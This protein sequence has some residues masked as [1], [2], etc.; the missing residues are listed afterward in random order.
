[1]SGPLGS[2][3]WMYAS[4]AEAEGQSLRFNDDDSAYLSW[5]PASAGNRKTWTWS[6]WVKRGNIGVRQTILATSNAAGNDYLGIEIQTG[7]TLLVSGNN[8]SAS[9]QISLTTNAV[10]RDIA[11]WY[12]IVLS[13]DTTQATSTDRVKLY[14]NG[15]LQTFSSATYP[16]LNYD[17][18]I[19]T[20]NSHNLGSFLPAAGLYLDGYLSEVN[21]I[22]G[23]ALDPT[24][25]GETDA[26][27]QWVP[28]IEPSV[29][30]GTNGFYLPFTNDYEVEGFNT[31]TYR[32][33]G[34]TQYIGGVG[35][36]PDLVW[37]KSRNNGTAWHALVDSIRGNTKFLYSN[38]TNAEAT[39]SVPFKSFD[40]DGFSVGSDTTTARTNVSGE[41]Y[42]AWAWDAGTGS[43]ASNTDGSITSSVK[44]NPD[45]GFSIVSYTGNGTAGA[46]IGHGLSSAPEII[47]TKN[48]DIVSNWFTFVS[49]LGAGK[50][51]LL[52]L[53][54][55]S[56]TGTTIWND[57]APTASVFSVG[58]ANETNGS[59]R[60]IIA[61]C[62]HSVAGYSDIGSYTGNGSSTG[63]TVTTGFKPAFVMIKRTDYTAGWI[64]FD[65]T[66]T[67]YN[68]LDK[69]LRA[70]SNAAD[71][72]SSVYNVDFNSDGFQ[73]TGTGNDINQSGGTYIY[74]AFADKREA[75]FWLDQSGNNNDWTNNNMQE[76]D[77]SLDS[78][79]NNFATIDPLG[80]VA[81]VFS[82]GNLK[83]VSS[84]D[85]GNSTMGLGSGAFYFEVLVSSNNNS[86][87][88]ICDVS[89]GMNPNRGGGWTSHGAIAYKANGDEY[90][91]TI[92]GSAT[93]RSYGSSYT[94][95][96]IIGVACDVDADTITFYKNGVSQGTTTEGPSYISS[97]GVYGALFYGNTSTLIANFGQDSSFAGNKVA[98]GNQDA[99]GKGDFY[100]EP[101]AG[102]LALC[103]DNLPDPAIAD[104]TEH[105]NT[106]L[107]TGDGSTQSITGVGFQ[108]DFTWIKE[109]PTSSYHAIY[110][111][112][113][114]NSKALSSN[115][116]DADY[117]QSS[118]LGLESF[119]TDGFTVDYPNTGNFYI[120]RNSESYVAWNWKADNTSGA[121]NTDG[122]I[123]ST[124]SAN[125]TAGFSIVTYDSDPSGTV[126][127][128]LSEAPQLIIEKKRDATSDWIVGHTAVDG[129]YDYVRLNTTASNANSA[130]AAPT[131][132]VFTPNVTSNSMIAYCFHSVESYSKIG[133]FTGNGST[134]GTFV[135]T[136][137]KPAFILWKRTS[138]TSN[139]IIWDDERSPYNQVNTVL[140]PDSNSAESTNTAYGLDMLSNGFKMR[141]SNATINGSGSTYIYMAFA[142]SPFKYSNAR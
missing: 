109:R 29:T 12:H 35:F 128:G 79:T 104:G 32:G 22:D 48:R 51:L 63:P 66:R 6:G 90:E 7:D 137:F 107:Y 54:N 64:M 2:S 46:T 73:L 70:D 24:S 30:Y 74:M 97:G 115:A 108:P 85:T 16:P 49:E 31:V 14:I 1:M 139:W 76:S 126:G 17:S 103:T 11:S 71:V 57:T 67:P 83:Y 47:I 87:I 8:G 10:F 121:S 28:I 40:A 134:D 136:G 15:V 82:E 26:N 89:V 59:T 68:P 80:S 33:N 55:A 9:V 114:G 124:V 18:R 52:N 45:Y 25:F 135:Y 113:R 116:T 21:F 39:S 34:S 36:E 105:F 77:I 88:G 19:N 130:V 78:P 102:Y 3:Q 99:N 112:V 91:L 110:D 43:A 132:T 5:T 100:Y 125:T 123:T 13:F 133:S 20:T 56:Y 138:S 111:V 127:H 93:T 120:N 41:T 84:A 119:D 86:Y 81:G 58:T 101:P 106:V 65:N 38:V 118:D 94:S 95:G 44:A 37:I 131:S 42:V 72:T 92:G 27:G 129:S 50:S 96:D 117:D 142:E 61:Y 60:D 53:T 140:F 98:Q 23:L 62:F 141:T 75:A 122:S 4:G 69:Y